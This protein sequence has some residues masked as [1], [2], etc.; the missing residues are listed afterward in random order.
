MPI[1]AVENCRLFRPNT[2]QPAAGGNREVS[3]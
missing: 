3:R 1:Q 2:A